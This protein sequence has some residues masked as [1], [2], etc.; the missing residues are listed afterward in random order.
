MAGGCSNKSPEQGLCWCHPSATLSPKFVSMKKSSGWLLR[1]LVA[2]VAHA[3]G[4]FLQVEAFAQ[5]ASSL[6]MTGYNYYGQLG[7]GDRASR[8]APQQVS[9]DA[10]AASAGSP[11]RFSSAPTEPCGPREEIN[12]ERL[13]TGLPRCVLP[14]CR[15]PARPASQL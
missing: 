9:N 11:T 13:E 6:W 2:W 14:L 5:N 10:V 1:T 8:A 4:G 3:F 12:S 7:L 15:F